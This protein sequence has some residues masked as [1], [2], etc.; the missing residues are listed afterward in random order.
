MLDAVGAAG[1]SGLSRFFS[2]LMPL[3]A[4][5]RS[6]SVTGSDSGSSIG[7]FSD[8]R[9]RS[10]FASAACSLAERGS[11][12]G[13]GALGCGGPGGGAGGSGGLRGGGGST[14][15]ARKNELAAVGG[16]VSFG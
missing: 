11:P 14:D 5:I 1:G 6:V 4:T 15:W 3:M 8:S 12:P 7:F 2:T 10:R 9:S 16:K 13:G